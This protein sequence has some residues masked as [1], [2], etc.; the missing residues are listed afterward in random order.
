[1]KERQLLQTYV[2]DDSRK[3]QVRRQISK[4]TR[5][6]VKN[7][8]AQR[9]NHTR[10]TSN[11]QNLKMQLYGQSTADISPEDQDMPQPM[12][13]QKS[14]EDLTI[15]DELNTRS[16]SLVEVQQNENS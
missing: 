11:G 14:F 10:N 8:L 15:A 4:K 9:K 3:I 6:H 2:K 13:M 7:I 5:T 16:Q 12:I 1:M